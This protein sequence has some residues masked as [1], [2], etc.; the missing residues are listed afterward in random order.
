MKVFL[1][2]P[3]VLNKPQPFL[4]IL[5][6][7]LNQTKRLQRNKPPEQSLAPSPTEVFAK[8]IFLLIFLTLYQLRFQ[9]GKAVF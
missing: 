9:L 7:T 5:Y 2:L 8:G 4:L 3:H 1:A 6:M